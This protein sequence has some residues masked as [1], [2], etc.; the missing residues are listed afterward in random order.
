[1]CLREILPFLWL[2]EL[3]HPLM[4]KFYIQQMLRH[5]GLLIQVSHYPFQINLAQIAPKILIGVFTVTAPGR[6]FYL[7]LSETKIYFHYKVFRFHMFVIDHSFGNSQV[8]ELVNFALD[9]F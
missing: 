5:T 1:M 3:P 6:K 2:L 9:L 4:E 7:I 8:F